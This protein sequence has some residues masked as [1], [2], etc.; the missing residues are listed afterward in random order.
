MPLSIAGRW[1]KH[2]LEVYNRFDRLDDISCGKNVIHLT[3]CLLLQYVVSVNKIMTS[4]DEVIHISV[5]P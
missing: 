2:L 5:K 4:A 1:I 3:D